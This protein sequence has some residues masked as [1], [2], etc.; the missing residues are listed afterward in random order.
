MTKIVEL[1]NKPHVGSPEDEQTLL[2]VMWETICH[3]NLGSQ[4]PKL[5]FLKNT[6]I[7]DSID[8]YD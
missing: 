4:K 6:E 5:R 2:F 1:G 8:M 7:V 3:C